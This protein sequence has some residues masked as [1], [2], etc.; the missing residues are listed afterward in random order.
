MP[1]LIRVHSRDSRATKR[2]TTRRYKAAEGGE[3]NSETIKPEWSPREAVRHGRS[4]PRRVSAGTREAK[5]RKK[6]PAKP[7][8]GFLASKLNPLFGRRAEA[9]H[10]TNFLLLFA[11]IRGIHGQQKGRD[12][13]LRR[14]TSEPPAQKH[15]IAKATV[16]GRP[17]GP[18]LPTEVRNPELIC[19]RMTRI[20]AND[21]CY[22]RPFA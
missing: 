22:S 12:A 15:F 2:K 9:G 6:P 1:F 16:T 4:P 14:P 3:M 10:R 5:G 19:P 21:C 8:S 11:F 17:S 18:S 20:H 7:L 13:A